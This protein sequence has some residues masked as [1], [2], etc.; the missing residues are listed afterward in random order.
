MSYKSTATR[1]RENWMTLPEAINHICVA[2]QW[3]EV[4]AQLQLRFALADET[5]NGLRNPEGV[6]FF[7]DLT[8]IWKEGESQEDVKN[9][10]TSN[11][12]RSR[13]FICLLYTSPSPR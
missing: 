2:N 13:I 5:D 8:V 12:P 11:L 6:L 7:T 4:T 3:D 1:E 10:I 9:R